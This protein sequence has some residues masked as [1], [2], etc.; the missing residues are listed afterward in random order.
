MNYEKLEKGIW[1]V[2][3]DK[4]PYIEPDFAQ[5][6]LPEAVLRLFLD[7]VDAKEFDLMLFDHGSIDGEKSG[8]VFMTLDDVF[9]FK[10]IAKRE[11]HSKFESQIRFD[12][13]KMIEG[14]YP[15]TLETIFS[16]SETYH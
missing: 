3:D 1:L 16:S 13:C 11:A 12:V 14:E 5:D 6:D 2:M 10:E 4:G 9:R 15:I 7:E 8:A